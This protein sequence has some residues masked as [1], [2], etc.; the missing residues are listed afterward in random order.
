MASLSLFDVAG[1]LLLRLK[2][3][4]DVAL[5]GTE[6]KLVGYNNGHQAVVSVM[7]GTSISVTFDAGSVSGSAGCNQFQAACAVSAEAIEIGMPVATRKFCGDPEG[8][9][10]QAAAFLAALPTAALF[11]IEGDQLA[12]RTSDGARVAVFSAGE[13]SGC[14]EQ[15]IALSGPSS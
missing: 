11:R 10:D 12:L 15:G 5:I 14:L 2:S 7:R 4:V 9:M 6:W 1:A 8:V 3:S 13:E